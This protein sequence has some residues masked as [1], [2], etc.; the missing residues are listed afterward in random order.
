MSRIYD[1]LRDLE[2]TRPQ[3]HLTLQPGPRPFR[4]VTVASNKGGVGKTTIALNLAVYLRALREDL[5]ILVIGLDDQS[6]LERMFALGPEEATQDLADALKRHD[7]ASAIRMGQYGVSYVPTSRR[8]SDLKKSIADV[9]YLDHAL[10]QTGFEGLVVIDTKSDLEIL[11]TNALWTSDL[12]IVVVKDL[13]SLHEAR[14][15]F[16]LL[17]GWNRPKESARVLL[18]LVDLR[19]KFAQAGTPDVLALLLT[20]IRALG[21]PLFET[22]LSRSPKIESLYTNPEEAAASILHGAPGSLVHE[23]M[24]QLAEEVLAAL[25]SQAPAEEPLPEPEPLP[26]RTFPHSVPAPSKDAPR[27]PRR[28]SLRRLF[29]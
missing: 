4:V 18:S 14:R 7:L 22:F 9:G 13:A 11:T 6:L 20:R 21:L 24:V 17:E 8:I 25:P 10:R 12:G 15:V 26:E 1:A 5:P 3:V 16:E 27:Q 23:Q 29:G 28:L 2:D 19:I